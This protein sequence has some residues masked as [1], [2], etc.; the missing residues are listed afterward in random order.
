MNAVDKFYI[1]DKVVVITGGAGLLGLKHAEAVIEG[2]GIP[3]L[4][5]VSE[6]AIA[7][8]ENYLK[9]KYG[10]ENKRNG[11]VADITKR[12]AIEQI[13]KK[14]LEQYGHIDVLINNAANNPKVETDSTNMK[15]IQFENFPLQIWLDDLAVGLTG[16]FICSQVFG[17]IM[18]KQGHGVILN[19]S[20]DLGIIAPDQRIYRKEGLAD[21]EQSVK[22]VTYS[23][24]KHGLIGLTKYL[25][26]YYAEKGVRANTLCPAGVYNGQNDEFVQKL[27][28]LIPMGRMADADEYKGTILYLISDASSYMTGSTIIVDGGRT[29]W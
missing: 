29:C 21:D 6:T 19:I 4:I 22:P 8:A 1:K 13:A 27:T 7:H 16:S 2:K 24:I 18:A 15:A 9:E 3:V 17:D 25:S 20:S 5:D 28:N 14:L 26:T 10:T 23:V 12:E 11:Y